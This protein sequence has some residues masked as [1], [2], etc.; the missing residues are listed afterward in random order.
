VWEL[1]PDL[2]DSN[3]VWSATAAGISAVT[4]S[5]LNSPVLKDNGAAGNSVFFVY[6]PVDPNT[7]LP[8]SVT[9]FV[10]HGLS[11]QA[12]GTDVAS[13][14]VESGD[15]NLYVPGPLAASG[16][17]LYFGT[18][19]V[20]WQQATLAGAGL[21]ANGAT[22]FCVNMDTAGTITPASGNVTVRNEGGVSGFLAGPVISD[23]G[24]SGLS[25]YLVGFGAGAGGLTGNT[26]FGYDDTELNTGAA[27]S[28][29]NGSSVGAPGVPV[30]ATPA[31]GTGSLSAANEYSG[32]SLF[33]V[34][35]VGGISVYN[36]DTLA[37]EYAR[38]YGVQTYGLPIVASPVTNGRYLVLCSDAG[39]SVYDSDTNTLAANLPL[40]AAEFSVAAGYSRNFRIIATPVIS[41]GF[42]IIPL[43]SADTSGNENQGAGALIAINLQNPFQAP[44]LVGTLGSTVASPIVSR[45]LVYSVDYRSTVN[46]VDFATAISGGNAWTQFKFD[47]AKT[48]N[49]T[50]GLVTPGSSGGCFISTVK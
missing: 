50:A 37:F 42:L 11:A 6:S 31:L 25:I 7:A 38:T 39:V 43:A 49:N 26:I 34:D 46:K 12:N 22:V 3:V 21:P 15:T 18:A 4:S 27:A 10:L 32:N 9:G 33:V 48:G 8:N 13:L 17:S 28:T 23:N 16:S 29:Q 30:L 44:E 47:A 19:S 35:S 14:T 20:L 36:K 41:N 2:E 1:S 24:S 5:F 40:G 45:D